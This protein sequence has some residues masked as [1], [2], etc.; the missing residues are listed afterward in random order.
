MNNS[1]QNNSH[2]VSEKLEEIFRLTS[3]FSS[4]EKSELLQALK[5]LIGNSSGFNVVLGGS[6]ITTANLVIQIQTMEK[7]D[8]AEVFKAIAHV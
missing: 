3:N 6:N 1:D 8:M 7:P 4:E 2:S 5:K